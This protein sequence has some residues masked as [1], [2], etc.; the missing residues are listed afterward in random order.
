M[1]VTWPRLFMLLGEPLT[2][3]KLPMFVIRPFS[4]KNGAIVG[5]PV[6]GLTT[7]FVNAMPVT[8][9]RSLA[10]SAKESSPSS[11][12]PRSRMFPSIQ[13][14]ACH[15]RAGGKPEEVAEVEGIGDRVLR[16]AHGLASVGD[17]VRQAEAAAERPQVGDVSVLPE[18]GNEGRSAGHRVDQSIVRNPRNGAS[19]VDR[20]GEAEVVAVGQR[21][22]VRRG[23]VAPPD[24][25]IHV[26]AAEVVPSGRIRPADHRALFVQ[27]A[28]ARVDLAAGAAQRIEELQGV[29]RVL[30]RVLLR[31]ERRPDRHE[32]N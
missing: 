13:T 21:P 14:V 16:P 10:E 8:W 3:P 29:T 5:Y 18:G 2:P 27:G 19:R 31:R 1:P 26:A 15:S 25:V 11:S 9:P 28:A 32:S 24:G 20:Y 30:C 7:V 22:E 23:A 12:V 6:S 4:Q 17:V